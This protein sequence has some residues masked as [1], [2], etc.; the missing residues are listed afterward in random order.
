VAGPGGRVIG[1]D[2][3][4]EM[5][6]LARR[7]QPGVASRIGYDNVTFHRARIQDLALRLE[8]LDAWLAEHPIRTAADLGRCEGF[9][10]RLRA[11]APLV[12]DASVDLVLSNC[13][14]RTVREEDREALFREIFRCSGR[15]GGSRSATSCRMSPCRWR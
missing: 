14:L 7:H 1:V 15:A 4:D 11:E 6:A 13:V 9:L 8:E 12:P 5:L 10:A 2:F 3:N